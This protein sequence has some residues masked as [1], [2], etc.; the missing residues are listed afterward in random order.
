MEDTLPQNAPAAVKFTDVNFAYG[1][2]VIFKNVSFAIQVGEAVGVIGPNGGGKTTLLKLMMGFLKPQ[3]GNIK[4][5]GLP[6][7]Q[8]IGKI[9]YVPQVAHFDRQFPISVFEL[10]LS[11]RLS[12]LP[13]YGSYR[14]QACEE[15]EEMLAK[16]GLLEFKDRSFGTL[17]GGQAQRALIAR[18]LIAKPELLLLDEPT[19][20]VDPQAEAYIYGLL[21]ELQGKIAIVMVTHDLNAAIEQVQRVLCVQNNVISLRPEEVCEHF[22]VGLYHVPLIKLDKTT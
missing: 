10:V 17:S 20:S 22:A 9:G 21:K 16:V 12:Q 6:S 11:G 18:A 14:R 2:N 4:L 13:W 1:S 15:A 8:A 3:S 7:S 19:A 5:F